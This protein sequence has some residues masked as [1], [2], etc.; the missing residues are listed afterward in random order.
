MCTGD[1]A[2]AVFSISKRRLSGTFSHARSDPICAHKTGY[3]YANV[4]SSME[5]PG[6]CVGSR[7]GM[8]HQRRSLVDQFSIEKD[9]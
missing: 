7:C 3:F 9:F 2:L 5:D 8:W 4:L 1:F 6:R